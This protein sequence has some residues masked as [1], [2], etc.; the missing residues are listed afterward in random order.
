MPRNTM[1]CV[2]FMSMYHCIHF[3]INSIGHLNSLT[4][5]GWLIYLAYILDKERERERE[6]KKKKEKKRERIIYDSSETLNIY[7]QLL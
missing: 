6:R 2:L 4:L 1:S 3:L 7:S 5:K